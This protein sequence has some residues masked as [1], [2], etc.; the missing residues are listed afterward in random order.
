MQC[1]K[2]GSTNISSGKRG[3]DLNKAF[4]G[5]LIFGFSGSDEDVWICNRCGNKWKRQEANLVQKGTTLGGWRELDTIPD[6]VPLPGN[7]L[8]EDDNF[9]ENNRIDSNKAI[10]WGIILIG[11][12]VMVELLLE[13]SDWN[14][15]KFLLLWHI[16]VLILVL[17]GLLIYFL[18]ELI[19][20]D[21]EPEVKDDA[22]K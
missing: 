9:T 5:G 7:H 14:I 17:V 1:S 6:P 12:L 4:A 18:A 13:A 16:I 20:G 22:T 2:C 10:F 19:K 8:P 3:L 11:G 21:K 15:P